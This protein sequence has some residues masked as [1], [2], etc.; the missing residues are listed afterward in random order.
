LARTLRLPVEP[1]ARRGAP[2]IT[3]GS[4]IVEIGDQHGLWLRGGFR[5]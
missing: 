1:S 3:T 2:E 4:G 5:I